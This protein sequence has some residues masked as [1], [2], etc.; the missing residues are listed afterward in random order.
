VQA[1]RYII[2]PTEVAPSDLARY[3]P[4]G[5]I[6]ALAI[7]GL[8]VLYKGMEKARAA[9]RE[10][11]Y[12]LLDDERRRGDRL[13]TEMAKL[14]TTVQTGAMA[15]VSDATRAVTDAMSLLRRQS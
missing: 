1:S 4:V 3:G 13:E 12:A 14:L 10:K 11:L 15:A 9:E 5:I 6:A 8:V 7:M 2:A